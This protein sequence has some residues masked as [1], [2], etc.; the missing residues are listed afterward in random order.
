MLAATFDP[1]RNCVGVGPAYTG[2][3]SDDDGSFRFE[4]DYKFA[5]KP[6]CMG[7]YSFKGKNVELKLHPMLCH[8][9]F[10]FSFFRFTFLTL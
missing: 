8:M 9:Q 5:V 6:N 4:T 7:N 1:L 2:S 3:I 10:G